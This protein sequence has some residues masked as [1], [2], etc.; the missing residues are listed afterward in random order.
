[1]PGWGSYPH[2]ARLSFLS[3]VL[4]ETLVAKGG[5]SEGASE[6]ITFSSRA[7]N[8]PPSPQQVEMGRG[9]PGRQY[10]RAADREVVWSLKRGI[11][12]GDNREGRKQDRS[13]RGARSKCPPNSDVIPGSTTSVEGGWESGLVRTPSLPA[14]TAVSVPYLAQS[15]ARAKGRFWKKF[16]PPP[17][18]LC[19]QLEGPASASCRPPPLDGASLSSGGPRTGIK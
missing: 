10:H 11:R 1:M 12:M 2:W 3:E 17:A 19:S 13:Y 15:A 7:G 9:S 4:E 18:A 5:E 14:A 8:Q 16:L 6:A